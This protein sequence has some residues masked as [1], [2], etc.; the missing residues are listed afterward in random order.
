MERLC[1]FF[2]RSKPT[3][4]R[5]SAA[6]RDGW[7]YLPS[8]CCKIPI[9]LIEGFAGN[10][11]SLSRLRLPLQDPH[12]RSYRVPIPCRRRHAVKLVDLAKIA[13]GLHVTTV[14]SEHELPLGRNHPHQPLPV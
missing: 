12:D 9:A 6:H 3:Q 14:H 11:T 13:D 2:P 4:S 10:R 5:R 7:C 1:E 8:S